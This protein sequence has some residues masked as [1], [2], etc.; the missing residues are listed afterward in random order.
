[1]LALNRN[2]RLKCLQRLDR[3]FEADRSRVDVV[4]AGG[5]GDDG[6]DEVV[7]QNVRPDLLPNQLRCLAAQDIHLHRLLERSQI[8][9]TLPSIMPP[10]SQVLSLR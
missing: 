3:S 1:M 7:S 8:E 5:L 6:A 9:F 10:L 2:Q 4:F